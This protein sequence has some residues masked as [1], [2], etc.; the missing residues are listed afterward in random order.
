VGRIN[1]YGQTLE[2]SHREALAERIEAFS[3]LGVEF[4]YLASWRDPFG[5]PWRYAAEI[6]SS[7][8][9]SEKALLVVFVRE[10]GS[11]RAVGWRGAEVKGRVPD[12]VWLKALQETERDLGR[13]HPSLAI[14]SLSDKL[15]SWLREG[16]VSRGKDGGLSP[17]AVAGIVLGGLY[18]VVRLLRA[19]HL[20]RQRGII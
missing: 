20:R 16:K 8:G 11:W 9:L 1:D 12:E 15:L 4:W 3:Q 18:L 17:G 19:I 2:R 13:H 5:N 6:A 10:G 14:L 7:W